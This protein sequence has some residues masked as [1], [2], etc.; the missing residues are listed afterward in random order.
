MINR[1]LTDLIVGKIIA[2]GI[3]L[4]SLLNFSLPIAWEELV[5][6]NKRRKDDRMLV[7]HC[8]FLSS[9]IKNI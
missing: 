1:I 8:E 6:S 4:W 2:K 9:Y 5:D 3:E 7:V